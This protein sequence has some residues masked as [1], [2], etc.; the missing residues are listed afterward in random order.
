[1]L[2]SASCCSRAHAADTKLVHT[3]SLL[4]QYLGQHLPAGMV[5]VELRGQRGPPQ[6]DLDEGS[7]QSESAVAGGH[8]DSP[9]GGTHGDSAAGAC[10][11]GCYPSAEDVYALIAHL[12]HQGE[13]ASASFKLCL[14]VA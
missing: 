7:T 6:A 13:Q 12:N 11:W 14:P 9:V 2:S 10:T 3:H 8:A 5:C 4:S 1:M